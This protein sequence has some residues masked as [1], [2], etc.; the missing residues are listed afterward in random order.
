MRLAK[1]HSARADGLAGTARVMAAV[2][3]K[4]IGLQMF[5]LGWRAVAAGCDVPL[6][7]VVM[8]GSASLSPPKTA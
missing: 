8:T 5:P 3:G 2:V 7:F 4:L 6:G 1:S